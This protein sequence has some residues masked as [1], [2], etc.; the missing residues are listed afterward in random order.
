MSLPQPPIIRRTRITQRLH[1]R[2]PLRP[3]P[4]HPHRRILP[5]R[6]TTPRLSHRNMIS[7][8]PTRG[9]PEAQVPRSQADLHREKGPRKPQAS[10][11]HHRDF[12]CQRGPS[13]HC[14]WTPHPEPTELVIHR[15]HSESAEKMRSPNSLRIAGRKLPQTAPIQHN[16]KPFQGHMSRRYTLCHLWGLPL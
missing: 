9:T 10:P 6:R 15:N 1:P 8:Q 14:G 7:S 3:H 11:T 5:T 12:P 4:E 2:T 13:P 16:P